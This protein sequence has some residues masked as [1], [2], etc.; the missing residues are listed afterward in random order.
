MIISC[1]LNNKFPWRKKFILQLFQVLDIVT[2]S[3]FFNFRSYLF[4]FI[5]TFMSHGE[6]LN[7]VLGR[8]CEMQIYWCIP[9]YLKTKL[10][11]MNLAL[12]SIQ[13]FG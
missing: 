10:S 1:K 5:H 8:S 13:V 6:I 3:Q 12:K 2:Y 4:S 9:K 11:T 7:I